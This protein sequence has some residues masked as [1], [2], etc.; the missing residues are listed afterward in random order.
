M[1]FVRRLFNSHPARACV[2]ILWGIQFIFKMHHSTFLFFTDKKHQTNK[3][4]QDPSISNQLYRKRLRCVCSHMHMRRVGNTDRG[5]KTGTSNLYLS[6]QAHGRWRMWLATEYGPLAIWYIWPL[7]ARG[8][9]MAAILE[10]HLC[11][12]RA[13]R[14]FLGPSLDVLQWP[15]VPKIRPRCCPLV[16]I[17]PEAWGEFDTPGLKTTP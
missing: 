13:A 2:L 10:P 4:P 3:E 16:Q 14:L 8:W 7:V 1:G 6:H 9:A 5:L 17:W 11:P 15:L 12:W